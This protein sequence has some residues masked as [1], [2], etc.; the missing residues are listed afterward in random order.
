[1]AI[2]PFVNS[3]SDPEAAKIVRKMFYNFFSSLD[4]LDVELSFIDASLKRRGLYKRIMA[5][6]EISPQK[7]G[8]FLGVDAIISGE[9]YIFGKVYALLYS[10]I[11]AGLRARMVSSRTGQIVWELEKTV[12]LGEG[13]VPL[14]LLGL[15]AGLFKSA[16]NYRQASGMKAA[17]ALCMEMI[18]TIPNPPAVAEAPPRIQ[19]LVHN[20]AGRLLSPGD[21][22]KVVLIGDP[23][24]KGNW[25]ISPL[26][27]NLSLTEKERGIYIG[28]YRVTSGD[29]LSQ[30]RIVGHLSSK[31]GAKSHWTDVL[32]TVM[33]GEPTPL[34]PVI[35]QDTVL[36]PDKSPYLVEEA[37][38]V[39]PG[40]KLIADPGTVIRFRQ[41]GLI[42]RG[43]VQFRGTPENPI[44]FSGMGSSNWKGIF[45]D[46]S[47]E[48]NVF[49]HC[50]ISVAEYGLRISDSRAH[51]ERSLFQDNRWA[52]VLDGGIA[53]IKH[54]LVRT[55]DKTGI[56]AR[57]AKLLIRD[58]VISEN[59]TGGILLEASDARIEHNNISNN[60][61]W[62]LNILENH[63]QIH[64]KNNWWGDE[65][66]N[67]I[68]VRGAVNVEPVLKKPIVYELFEETTY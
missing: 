25:E 11:R 67:E 36:T 49:S 46:R 52:V 51:I 44:R 53:E 62:E 32:G 16:I 43:E 57:N 34:P 47:H 68:R 4:Y 37:T 2:L 66:V 28:A 22:L 39:R 27:K 21:D 33:L 7:L 23:G 15:A 24:H 41:L 19:G 31:T 42:I 1:V 9:V 8:Q 35:S 26:I 18:S 65:D 13:D 12:R 50:E 3:T 29:H 30:G 40:V 17:S 6:K 5:G 48:N 38:V 63:G 61:E 59:R 10:D 14:S 54:S 45:I 55:S 60:G 64:A 20:G 58:S 56:S